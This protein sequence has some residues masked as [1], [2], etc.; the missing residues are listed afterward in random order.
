M[1]K[2]FFIDV[3]HFSSYNL[4]TFSPSPPSL[5]IKQHIFALGIC[6]RWFSQMV[7][8][9]GSLPVKNHQLYKQIKVI[10]L[11]NPWNIPSWKL[12]YPLFQ[13]CFKMIFLTSQVG[14]NVNSLEKKSSQDTSSRQRPPRHWMTSLEWML[15]RRNLL[16]RKWWEEKA[17]RKI[18][19][20][21]ENSHPHEKPLVS[22]NK[23]GYQTL[24]FLR[25]V[26][27][28]GLID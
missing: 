22:V 6:L 1:C 11:K 17:S 27:W 16:G 13:A 4:G 14:I 21:P 24:F 12:R 28:G 26:H 15:Q 2:S 23:A 3:Y 10:C 7:V 5:K 20:D 19:G 8:Q 25:A 18:P 9:N